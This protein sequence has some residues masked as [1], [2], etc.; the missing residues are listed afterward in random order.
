MYSQLDPKNRDSYEQK[1]S[2]EIEQYE[3]AHAY[4]K[5]HL[6]GRTVIPEKAWKDERK[7]LLVERLPLVDMYHNLKDDV[8]KIE[9]LRRGADN[10][11]RDI[12]PE[13]TRYKPQDVVL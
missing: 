6:N 4:I 2:G 8:K 11:M 7:A 9:S 10:L 1:Y 5:A 13:Q 3:S 12:M